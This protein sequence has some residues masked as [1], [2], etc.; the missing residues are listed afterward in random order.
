MGRIRIPEELLTPIRRIYEEPTFCVQMEGQTSSWYR[1]QMGIRQGC[2]L[3]PYL[4]VIV[5]TVVFWDIH[6]TLREPEEG[7][8]TGAIFQDVF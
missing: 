5:L 8:T 1:Q 6:M 7:N 2:P 4:F 3:S